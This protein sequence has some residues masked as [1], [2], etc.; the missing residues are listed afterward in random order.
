MRKSILDYT[1]FNTIKPDALE[2]KPIKAKPFPLENFDEDIGVA[3]KHVEDILAKIT[4]AKINDVNSSPAKQKLI[5]NMKYKAELC[6]KMLKQLI[7][8]S[9]ELS[10]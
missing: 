2:P 1:I 7:T 3:Y 5:K 4:A 8:D 9:D 10:Y 6:K